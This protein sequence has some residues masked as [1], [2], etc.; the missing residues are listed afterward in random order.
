MKRKRIVDT[1]Y[2]PRG[3]A[4]ENYEDENMSGD[5]P[6]RKPAKKKRKVTKDV[7]LAADPSVHT[8]V[9]EPDAT[10]PITPSIEA[11]SVPLE[12]TVKTNIT[13]HFDKAPEPVIS[14]YP[15]PVTGAR[16]K[17]VQKPSP[18]LPTSSERDSNV[19]RDVPGKSSGFPTKRPR[20]RSV[21]DNEYQ[22]SS[23]SSENE[24]EEYRNPAVRRNEKASIVF[25]FS[26]E[27]AKRW[28][29]AINL[30]EGLYNDDEKELFIRL[31][32]RGFEPIV[33][34]NW[35]HDFPTLPESL[36]PYDSEASEKPLID[37]I[38]SSHMYAIK[39]LSSLF[40]VGSRVR[41]CEIMR[42]QPE[43]LIKQAIN[44]YI[45]WAFFDANLRDNKNALPVHVIYGQKKGESTLDAVKAINKRLRKLAR[46]H[47]EGISVKTK[48]DFEPEPFGILNQKAPSKFPLLIGFIICGPIFA[49]LTHTTDPEQ[50]A[51]NED[52]RFISQFDLSEQ[53]QEVWNSF[54]IAIAVM[55]IRRTML[56]LT[57]EGKS[58]YT[59]QASRNATDSD[60]DL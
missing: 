43:P 50:G 57:K 1:T 41:D 10:L 56:W 53:G 35:R 12:K 13:P 45:Q 21:S 20:E 27:K 5:A 54:A 51:V 15:T 60:V 49:I 38:K 36:Y 6:S 58:G 24:Y 42:T 39:A 47:G 52:G 19:T 23:H 4:D 33:P 40:A 37:V 48:H 2:D 59:A 7:P 17:V 29:T 26:V 31:A 28:G 8:P 34:R 9:K 22:S 3:D 55:H 46:Q 14:A 32:M 16:K 44:N 11:T 25:D 18:T 30:P